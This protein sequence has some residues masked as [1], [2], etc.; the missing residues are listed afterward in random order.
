MALPLVGGA[1]ALA[2]REFAK[3]AL[4]RKLAEAAAKGTGAAA[5][6]V[7]AAGVGEALVPKSKAKDEAAKPKR[8]ESKMGSSKNADAGTGRGTSTF[9]SGNKSFKEAFREAR[10]AGQDN[11]TWNGKKYSTETAEEK[12]SAAS[13]ESERETTDYDFG[14]TNPSEYKRGGKVKKM[15]KGGSA[16]SAS[17]RGDGCAQR[18][19]TRGRMV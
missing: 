13:S 6:G 12:K 5:L 16:N 14:T 4:K 19:K 7:G 10:N 8:E 2:S 3:Q 17:R 1:A 18:G 11:F 9:G 15:A